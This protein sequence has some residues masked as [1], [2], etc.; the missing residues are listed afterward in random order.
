M[1]TK[2]Q[3]FGPRK[4]TERRITYLSVGSTKSQQK[5]NET[6][7]QKTKSKFQYVFNP[8]KNFDLKD[9]LICIG[10]YSDEEELFYITVIIPLA[11]T[12]LSEIKVLF[13]I[14]KII[15]IKFIDD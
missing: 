3:N 8:T 10:E 1:E 15:L 4:S 12:L 11:N 5:I 6:L 9:V 13:I 7:Y 14:N 2:K